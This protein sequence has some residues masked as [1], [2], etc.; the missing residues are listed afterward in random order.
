MKVLKI[1]ALVVGGVLLLAVLLVGVALMPSVQTWAVRRALA[2]RPGVAITIGRVAAGPSATTLQDLRVEQNGLVVTARSVSARYSPWDYVLHQRVTVDAVAVGGLVV[3]ARQVAAAPS[4]AP[5][6]PAAGPSPLLAILDLGAPLPVDVRLGLISVAGRALLPG[7]RTVGFTVDGGGIAPGQQGKLQWTVDYADGTSGAAVRGAHA[8]GSLGVHLAADRRVE[9]VDFESSA[10]L[11]GAGLPADRFQLTARA[12]QPTATADETLEAAVGLVR[13]AAVTPL[14]KVQAAVRRSTRELTGTWTLSLAGDEFARWLAGLGWPGVTLAGQGRFAVQGAAGT[15]TASGE[16]TGAVADLA[17]LGP[18]FAAVGSL[19]LQ[20]AFDGAVT[21]AVARLG[22]LEVN[23]AGSDGRNLLH[24]ATAQPVSFQRADGRLELANPGAE[25]AQIKIQELPLA[26]TQPF[27]KPVTIEGGTLSGAFTIEAAAD[28]RQARLR[29]IQPLTCSGVILRDQQ[30][31]LVD[32]M[33]LSLSPEVDYTA[34][35]TTAAVPDLKLRLPAGDTVDG[36]VSA[37]VTRTP[38]GPAVDFTAH[39]QERVVSVLR[40]FLP[41][42]PGP[43]RIES[44]AAGHWE[45]STLRVAKF[46]ST[47]RRDDGGLVASVETL[48]PL[49]ANLETERVVSAQAGAAAVRVQ[50]GTLPLALADA[51]VPQAKFDGVLQ[52]VALEVDLPAPDRQAIR[53]TAPLQVRG[54]GVTLHGQPLVQGLDLSADVSG[55]MQGDA[56]SGE[57][58]QVVLSQGAATLLKLAGTGA[59][60]LGPKLSASGKGHLEADLAALGRQPAF[61]SLAALGRGRLTADYDVATADTVHAK[62]GLMLRDLVTRAD[63]QALGDLD[64][65]ADA[66]VK[67]DGSGGSAKIPLTLSVG[68]RRSDIQLEASFG[69]TASLLTCNGRLTGNQVYADDFRALAALAPSSPAAEP[70]MAPGTAAAPGPSTAAGTPG[71]PVAAPKPDAEPFWHGVAGRFDVDLKQVNYG[72]TYVVRGVH[73]ALVAEPKRL[74]VEDLAGQFKN[75][76]FKVNGAIT[77]AAG[78]TQPYALAGTVNVPGFD[79]GALLRAAD[80]G[81]PPALESTVAINAKL[82]GRG[83]SLDDLVQGTYGQ[84]DLT[85]GKGV[86]RALGKKGEVASAASFALGLFGALRGSDTTVAVGQLAGLLNQMPFDQ[87][88]MHLERGADLNVKL[89]SLEFISPT[90]HLTGTGTIQYQPGVPLT[91]Q[92]LQVQLQLAGKAEL[93]TVLNRLRLLSGQQDAQGYYS[94]SSPFSVTGT[95]AKPNSSQLWKMVAGAAAGA[96]LQ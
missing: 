82:T 80:P 65:H 86:L 90:A 68:S 70:G 75:D 62:I 56:V 71:S 43:L 14:A 78:Q 30:R 94:M 21:E 96:L 66:T 89:S 11:E 81:E 59:A 52:G 23:V 28:G 17:R 32:G 63:N 57:I 88:K 46:A 44:S 8:T 36:S 41:F 49:T 19:R 35:R 45:G 4:P 83:A 27:V 53:M 22:R 60:H 29:A 47:V 40:P 64:L 54:L 87:F 6:A 39:F 84:F 25:L 1:A 92:P 74:A 2:G 95:L 72:S 76:A 7:D 77:F 18:P 5:G 48:Q 34:A 69:R 58:R 9:A 42:D 31:R 85:G 93:A 91:G 3:D 50:L 38:A 55:A 33:T 79:V 10:A 16:L 73:G 24:I 26:W 67:P 61:A 15:G 13:P 51:L 37:A 20:A 12:A